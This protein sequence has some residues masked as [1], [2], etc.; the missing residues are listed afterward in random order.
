MTS[1][2]ADLKGLSDMSLPN[3]VHSG[4]GQLPGGHQATKGAGSF[5]N[6]ALAALGS[7]MSAA[8]TNLKVAQMA[9]SLSNLNDQQLTQIGITRRDIKRHAE[10]LITYEY[11][12]L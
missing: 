12:G 10:H 9:R 5:L 4:A 2:K 6:R 1:V 11:D 3:L 8:F 7:A